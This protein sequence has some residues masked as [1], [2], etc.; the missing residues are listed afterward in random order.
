MPLFEKY[1]KQLGLPPILLAAFALQESTCNANIAGDS[2]GAFGLMQITRESRY[3][4]TP[5]PYFRLVLF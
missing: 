2:G 3:P 5:L 1:G 4:D